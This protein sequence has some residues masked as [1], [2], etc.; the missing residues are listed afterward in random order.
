MKISKKNYKII[1][2]D[3]GFIRD[4]G[5]SYPV[6]LAIEKRRREFGEHLTSIDIFRKYIL[7]EI[8]D[9]LYEYTWVDLF[10]G[11]G[12]LILP[13]LESIPLQKRI[14][15]FKEH[16][17]LFDIQKEMISS[18]INNAVRYGIPVEIATQNIL[19][20]DTLKEYPPILKRLKYPVYHIIWGILSKI[21]N[22][23]CNTF[24]V[25][26]KVIKIYIRLP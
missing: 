5:T 13:I 24:L 6:S 3:T 10:A 21:L 7:P 15:F 14:K 26:M 2:K 18:S 20:K 1:C 23:I 11:E 25:A 16:I 4:P 22:E 9:C 17:F 19:L 8:K 12:N